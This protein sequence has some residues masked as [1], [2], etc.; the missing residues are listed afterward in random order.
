VRV[1][2]CFKVKPRLTQF[3]RKNNITPVHNT[4]RLCIHRADTKQLLQANKWPSD[5]LISEWFFS[6]KNPI[7]AVNLQSE[8]TLAI[9]S[10]VSNDTSDCVVR[11]G[12]IQTGSGSYFNS[13]PL[14]DS[15]VNMGDL[16]DTIL[17]NADNS[18]SIVVANVGDV[19]DNVHTTNIVQN[20]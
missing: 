1:I 11:N 3:Q 6:N 10:S 19:V 8:S 13:N 7:S 9:E 15:S 17:F 2:S 12:P 20:G 14:N 16:D 18:L 4:F 5:I